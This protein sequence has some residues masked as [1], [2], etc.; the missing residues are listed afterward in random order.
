MVVRT[1][2]MSRCSKTAAS[3]GTTGRAIRGVRA[4][5]PARSCIR[6]PRPPSLPALSYLSQLHACSSADDDAARHLR[7]KRTEVGI[8]T[9]D[10][11]ALDELCLPI[12]HGRLELAIGADDGVRHVIA[13]RPPDSRARG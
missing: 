10:I 12:E 2:F 5:T 4:Y 6:W 11:E 3:A 8:C 1:T 9:G 7:V 13:I